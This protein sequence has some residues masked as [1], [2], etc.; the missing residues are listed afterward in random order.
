MILRQLMSNSWRKLLWLAPVGCRIRIPFIV[1]SKRFFESGA[2]L[3]PM[4]DARGPFLACIPRRGFGRSLAY[5]FS[6][7][8]NLPV[9]TV[10]S[11]L[12]KLPTPLALHDTPVFAPPIPW[13]GLFRLLVSAHFSKC[14]EHQ[15]TRCFKQIR[16]DHGDGG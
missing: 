8:S 5:L 12:A 9:A 13:R 3:A 15:S 7:L 2:H 16:R 1:K 10:G 4:L 14:K 6:Q 11:A